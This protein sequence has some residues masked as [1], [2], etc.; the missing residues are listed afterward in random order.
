MMTSKRP[1]SSHSFFSARPFFS[2]LAHPSAS[3]SESHVLS[4]WQKP[5]FWFIVVHVPSCIVRCRG[6]V[7]DVGRR[8]VRIHVERT[9]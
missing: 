6:T 3:Q 7:P 4:F 5:S 9:K 8:V 1:G 2:S